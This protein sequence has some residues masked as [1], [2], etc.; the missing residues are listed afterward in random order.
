MYFSNVVHDRLG[1]ETA[2]NDGEALFQQVSRHAGDC[3][4]LKIQAVDENTN[5][6]TLG[7]H[8]NAGWPRTILFS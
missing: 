7:I 6:F 2:N 3:F 8:N 1:A 4:A 5:Q